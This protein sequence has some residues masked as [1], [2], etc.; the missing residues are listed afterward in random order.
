MQL[1]DLSTLSLRDE[2]PTGAPGDGTYDPSRGGDLLQAY[3][4]DMVL[5]S[6]RNAMGEAEDLTREAKRKSDDIIKEAKDG[7]EYV[8]ISFDIDVMDPSYMPGTGT[9][10]SNGLT[11]RETFPLIRRLCAESNVVGFELVELLPYRDDGYQTVLNS[12]RIVRECLVGIAMRKK[13][14]DA[15]NYLSP[16]TADDGR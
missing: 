15:K 10:E 2:A 7:P 1:P 8:F 9:P 14:I 5:D 12:D 16:L 11:A 13:G 3:F 6:D 4:A